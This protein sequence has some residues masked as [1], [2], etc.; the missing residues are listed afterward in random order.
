MLMGRGRISSPKGAWSGK[1]EAS[2]KDKLD[3]SR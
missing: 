2:K 3:A 1:L